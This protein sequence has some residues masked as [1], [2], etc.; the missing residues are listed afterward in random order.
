[1]DK[2]I[3]R[4][5]IKAKKSVIAGALA[6]SALSFAFSDDLFEVSKNL[7]IFASIY[8][9]LNINYVDEVNSSHLIKTGIDAMLEDLDP[10]TEYVQESDI[11]DYKLKYV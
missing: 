5:G 7:D 6:V 10:Y 1:M 4:L 3:T 9:E 11:E 2:S 8:K